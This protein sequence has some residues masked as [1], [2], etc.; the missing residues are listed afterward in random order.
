LPQWNYSFRI[1]DE[2]KVAKA[3]IRE[4]PVHPKV[5]VEIAKAINGMNLKKAEKFL[6]NVI[7]QKEPVPFRRSNKKV[8]HKRGLSDR[9]GVPSGRYPIKAS[10]YVL[11][12]LENVENNAENKGLEV[13]KLV[14]SHIAVSKGLTLK[15]AMPRAFGRADVIRKFRS[16]VEVIVR[17][18]E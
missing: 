14:I 10:K 9:W 17:M 5:I 8:S 3:V 4:V 18:E 1:P 16:N 15:R 13:E 12:L 7:E 6:Q 11:K 2:S